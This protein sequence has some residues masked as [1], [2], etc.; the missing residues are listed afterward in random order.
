MGLQ[1]LHRSWPRQ[2]SWIIQIRY[3]SILI[4]NKNKNKNKNRNKNTTTNTNYREGGSAVSRLL[5]FVQGVRKIH[6]YS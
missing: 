5:F 6:P 1:R 2:I 3:L 4:K